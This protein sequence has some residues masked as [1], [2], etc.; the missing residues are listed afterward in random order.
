MSAD[1]AA[2]V[3]ALLEVQLCH[4]HETGIGVGVEIATCSD[5]DCMGL[6]SSRCHGNVRVVLT[7][8][9]RRDKAITICIRA[10]KLGLV[11]L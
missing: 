1:I 7:E 10:W 9:I 4:H 2:A 6:F 3:A 5:C 11:G 8:F